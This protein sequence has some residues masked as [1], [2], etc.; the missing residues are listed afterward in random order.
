M[1]STNRPSTAAGG[2]G[3]ARPAVP[4]SADYRDSLG[5][6][7]LLSLCFALSGMAALIYQTA[8]TRQ[9]AIVFGTSELAVATV[10]AAYMGGLALGAAFVERWLPRVERPVLTY[11]VLE[12]GI[13]ISAVLLVPAFLWLSQTLLVSFF[14]GQPA[15]PS[16]EQVGTSLFYLLSALLALF[17]PTTMMG[18]TLP[19]L[20]RHAVHNDGQ[21]GRRIGLLYAINTAGAVAGAL[22]TAFV[23]LPNV[24]LRLTIWIAAALNAAVF[25]L[26]AILARSAGAT[27]TTAASA[28]RVR[29]KF[30]APPDT[31]W[32]LPLMFLAGAVAFFQ[33]VLWNRM[34]GHV[35]GSSIYAFGVMVASFLAGIALG[36]A[37]GAGIARTRERA[38]W[39][40]GLALILAAACAAVAYSLLERVMP[41]TAG[42]MQNVV[43]FAGM[44]VPKNVFFAASL[45][46]PLTFCIGMTYPL[47]V[48]V[49]ATRPEDAAAASARVYA[50]NTFGAIVGSLVAGF[51]LIPALRYEGAIRAAVIAS[52]ALG[53]IAL[54]LLIRPRPVW[55]AGIATLAAMAGAA[56]FSPRIPDKLLVTSPLNVDRSGRMLYYDIGKSAS[57]VLLHQDGGLALR[58]N[59]LPEALMET[60]GSLPRFSGEFWLSPITAIARPDARS[61]LV[62]G[63]G[64]GVVVEGVPPSFR[65]IDVI[66]IEPL[67]LEANRATRQLRKRDPLTD[68][69]L[70]LMTNDARGALSLTAKRYDAIVSQP[71][72]PWTAGA[73][74]L[75]TREFMMLARERMSDA[76]VFIQWMNVAFL[77]EK[78]LRSLTAT[79]LDV[80]GELRVY[81]PDPSTLVFVASRQPFDIE[82][83]IAST[84]QPLNRAPFHYAR[85]GINGLE[86]LVAA[87]V[88]DTASA[89]ELASG[90]ALITDDNNRMATSSVYELG[91]GMNPDMAGRILAAYD[92]LQRRDS[93]VYQLLGGMLSYDYIA[94]R[95]AIFVALDASLVDRMERMGAILGA[96]PQG[97]YVRA[98][99]LSLRGKQSAGIQALRDAARAFPDSD[100]LRFEAIRPFLGALSAQRASP[101]IAAEAQALSGSAATV[102][103]GAQLAVAGKWAELAALDGEL[104]RAR[105]TDPWILEAIQLRA[106]WRSR[107]TTPER[108]RA[109]GDEAIALLD[110]LI[111][112]SPSLGLYG[113]RA[114]CGITA[115]RPEV[116]IESAWSYG[117]GAIATAAVLQ[118]AQRAEART[119]IE[120]ILR[121]LVDVEQ[122]PGVDQARLSEIRAG[123]QKG[124]QSLG[125]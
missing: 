120:G 71:S 123:L 48:R 92:P 21:I 20:A 88:L 39:G 22:V 83:R 81:R 14:G 97:E 96:T 15:P 17:L 32:V 72:H 12:L 87:L 90:A 7:V 31:V 100:M 36:G 38:A 46:L 114:R 5:V 58:T 89:R 66:E 52:A 30:A 125:S 73:S 28:A 91:R 47:A 75:Y 65:D 45:L 1:P 115:E 102:V 59:G 29:F 26:A 56:L 93:F 85:F 118:P 41:T 101:E 43:Q 34:L 117:R 122:K 16:S 108:K 62:V 98:L 57:V 111:L 84:G 18:A 104:A 67:V 49:L 44:S 61:M 116:V 11:A 35:L 94:R 19:L 53:L 124:L 2:L 119:N 121:L 42:L 6:L 55:V 27:H 51:V 63:Y 103:R 3:A 40:L 13:A 60:P 80:F 79:M 112:V 106:D 9:F 54:W 64:G 4:A 10:L 95:M 8:W 69:R 78:L 113:L 77:D 33:E 37:A 24:G 109:L 105:W 25:L 74:H 99:A 110:R 76:G 82:A 50:W 107:V 86:D 23:L 70:N 68:T